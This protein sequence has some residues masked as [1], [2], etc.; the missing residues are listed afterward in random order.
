MTVI[1]DISTAFEVISHNGTDIEQIVQKIG[2]VSAFVKI[3]PNVMRIVQTVIDSNQA[4]ISP[5]I[6]TNYVQ[7]KQQIEAFQSKHGLDVD[8][9]IGIDTW[10]KIESLIQ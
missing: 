2:G 10:N 1:N 4:V 3:L 5:Q 7:M 9:V 8:G 6:I